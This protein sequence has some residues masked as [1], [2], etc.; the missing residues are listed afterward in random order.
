MSKNKLSISEWADKA[1]KEQDPQSTAWD[2]SVSLS[3]NGQLNVINEVSKSKPALALGIA[4]ECLKLKS[5][6]E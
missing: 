4:M 3:S 5:E 1:I 2:I 6:S